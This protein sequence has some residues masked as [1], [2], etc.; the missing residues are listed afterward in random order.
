MKIILILI[1]V[2]Q[3]GCAAMAVGV[4]SNVLGDIV[5]DKIK[6]RKIEEPCGRRE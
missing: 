2:T 1:F 3:V 4:G 5:S 6:D